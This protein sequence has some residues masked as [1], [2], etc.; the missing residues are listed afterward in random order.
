MARPS[1]GGRPTCET[2]KSIDVRRWHREGLLHAHR[3]FTYNWKRDD[4][5]S[6]TIRVRTEPGTVVLIYNVRGRD[7]NWK[8][9]EQRVPITQ[10]DCR[11][12]GQRPWFICSAHSGGQY[13]GRRVAVLYGAGELFACRHCSR[14]TYASQQQS[15]RDRNLRVAQKIRLQLGG[16]P[17][18]FDEFPD[19]PKHM[20]QRTYL[21]LRD[22]AENA[23]AVSLSSFTR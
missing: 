2:Y 19:R 4:K 15:S 20:H 10:T 18:V 21:R 16:S 8:P 1:S 23:A 9:V 3:F 7:G 14:L 5:L 22:R 17:S 11:F 13:C 12:G 6:G